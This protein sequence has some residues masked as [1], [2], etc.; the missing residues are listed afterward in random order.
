MLTRNFCL[1]S[2]DLVVK[3]TL[4]ATMLKV[5]AATSFLMVMMI[6]S[7][8]LRILI[9]V[10]VS[11]LSLETITFWEVLRLITCVLGRVIFWVELARL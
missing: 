1:I 10:W 5:L 7:L 8:E 11:W 9:E 3:F 6:L 4:S 2:F